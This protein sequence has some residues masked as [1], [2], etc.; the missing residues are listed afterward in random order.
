AYGNFESVPVYVSPDVS[1]RILFLKLEEGE[2]LDSGQLVVIIDTMPYHLN[3]MEIKARQTSVYSKLE[4]MDAQAAIYKD[5][6][7]A[8]IVELERAKNLYKSG[9][10]TSQSLDD[11]N[12]RLDVLDSQIKS[13]MVQ[14]QSIKSDAAVLDQ[15]M[16][17]IRDKLGRC[18]LMNHM[19]GTVLE[20]Y[21]EAYEIAVTG[22]PVYKIANLNTLELRVYVS[23]AMLP[24]IE[25]GDQVRVLVDKDSKTNRELTGEVSWISSEA[26][27]TPKIIQTKEERVKLVYAIKIRV[28]NDGSLKIGMPG[29]VVF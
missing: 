28:K 9:A 3:L 17:L 1:G 7:K 24:G 12:G 14:K 21:A 13:V 5:Q 18:F 4:N 19:Q 15:N 29:E 8:L 10:A 11:L 16:L 23:G 26:E 22:K 20:K 25:L 2:K 27:F 6:K